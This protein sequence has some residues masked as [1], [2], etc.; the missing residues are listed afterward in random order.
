MNWIRYTRPFQNVV[1]AIDD[2]LN[3]HAC[4]E[5]TAD[6]IVEMLLSKSNAIK[7]VFSEEIEDPF[8]EKQTYSEAITIYSF[9]KHPDLSPKLLKIE[10]MLE[11]MEAEKRIKR[12]H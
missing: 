2:E 7:D 6:Q 3:V 8:N 1:T 10:S 4:T 9:Q 5:R 12:S 11:E